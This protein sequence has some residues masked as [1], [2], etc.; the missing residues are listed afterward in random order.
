MKVKLEELLVESFATTPQAMDARGT[1]NAHDASLKTCR[2][3][4]PPYYTCPECA[5]PVM[6][7]RKQED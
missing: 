1:V 5:S 3:S 7:E 2:F 6:D 4:C